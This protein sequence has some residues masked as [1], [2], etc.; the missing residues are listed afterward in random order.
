MDSGQL[1][2]CVG[3]NAPDTSPLFKQRLNSEARIN[4]FPNELLAD[5][6]ARL[7]PS[8]RSDRKWEI[9][10]DIL[11]LTHVCTRWRALALSQPELWT[12]IPIDHL[13]IAQ[14]LAGRSGTLPISISL[15]EV[16]AVTR[17]IA[18]FV[19]SQLHR[20][21]ELRVSLTSSKRLY[22]F[23]SHLI[24]H[25]A[26]ILDD[27][28][29]ELQ[30]GEVEPDTEYTE[31]VYLQSP[32]FAGT[33]PPLRALTLTHVYPTLV[34]PYELSGL[35]HLEL[36]LP[37]MPS[38]RLMQM[39]ASS[40]RLQTIT[41]A[42]PYIIFGQR[43]LETTGVVDLPELRRSMITVSAYPQGIR[44][45]LFRLGIPPRAN[46]RVAIRN[47]ILGY[48]AVPRV[49][50]LGC[51]EGIARVECTLTLEDKTFTMRAFREASPPSR[52]SAE[53]G[54]RAPALEVSHHLVA[55]SE[56]PRQSLESVLRN[57][58]MDVS[59]V[60][61]Y[62]ITGFHGAHRTRWGGGGW[63]DVWLELL[64]P[65]VALRRLRLAEFDSSTMEPVAAALGTMDGEEFYALPELQAVELVRLPPAKDGYELLYQA[66]L[67]RARVGKLQEATLE[68]VAGWDTERA[69]RLSEEASGRLVVRCVP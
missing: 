7:L 4:K 44:A 67:R 17:P 41:L 19:V 30:D 28:V 36:T 42:I 13:D 52:S 40:P 59:H 57:F 61:A 62:T 38:T 9:A 11:R 58:P 21:R 69:A 49:A 31:N 60:E 18:V 23:L 22:A 33:A 65:F 26:P 20:V 10:P 37:R 39:F 54:E 24:S 16:P 27:L 48:D 35:I 1:Q 34:L 29:L 25:P 32:L 15:R 8:P 3:L 68:D 14:E 6:F 43:S 63:R 47:E 5:I 66:L 56:D 64:R 51:L 55:A 46:L 2:S 53:P 12:A 50:N 45:L